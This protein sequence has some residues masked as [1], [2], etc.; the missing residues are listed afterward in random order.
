MD[1]EDELRETCE[2]LE[3]IN[4]WLPAG[5]SASSARPTRPMSGT[6]W[7][8]TCTGAGSSTSTSRASS[9][10]SGP[11]T[12]RRGPRSS[13]GS[14]GRRRAW[15]LSRSSSS[16]SAAAEATRPSRQQ[17]PASGGR[18][19]PKPPRPGSG[20]RPVVRWQRPTKPSR[21]NQRMQ[22]SSGKLGCQWWRRLGP[23]HLILVVI[24]PKCPGTV[25]VN[26]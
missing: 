3:R 1:D 10:W 9:R 26:R 16:N 4:A 25:Y 12:G 11:R 17:R 6:A 8:P 20:E 7:T 21:P 18:R 14:R 5:W 13:C 15:A 2:P 23:R 22:A 24:W 19:G